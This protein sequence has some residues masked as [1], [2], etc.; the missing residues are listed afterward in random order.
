MSFSK[1]QQTNPAQISN[2]ELAAL[3]GTN[4]TPADGNRFV[5]ES[6]SRITAVPVLRKIT[7]KLRSQDILGGSKV[8]LGAPGVNKLNQFV[9]A[10]VRYPFGT[11]AY[12]GGSLLQLSYGIPYDILDTPLPLATF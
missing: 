7:V 6:D 5:T 8:L 10:V 1:Q 4:G 2:Q 12:S 9:L 11:R 3:A